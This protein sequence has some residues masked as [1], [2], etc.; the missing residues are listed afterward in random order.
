MSE[1]DKRKQVLDEVQEEEETSE[2]KRSYLIW[3]LTKE[4]LRMTAEMVK[5]GEEKNAV[6]N[7]QSI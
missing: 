6:S 4:G 2:I 3:I 7:Y 5:M 1:F